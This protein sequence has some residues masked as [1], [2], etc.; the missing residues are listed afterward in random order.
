MRGNRGTSYGLTYAGGSIPAHAGQPHSEHPREAADQVYPRACGATLSP[1]C[2]IVSG[3]GLSPRMR[4]N[5]I[6]VDAH[7][8]LVRSIPAH[9]GQPLFR[10]YRKCVAS[11][12]P[13]A[14]GATAVPILLWEG[15]EGL[16]PRMRGNQ[17]M[18]NA[19]RNIARSIPAHA[20]QPGYDKRRA[21]YREVYPRACGATLT[22]SMICSMRHGLSP[23][24]RGNR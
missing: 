15:G 10:P 17:D 22:P 8:R 24:M 18:T 20:G 9:A 3:C 21:Q 1:P 4:G 19:A 11:V 13:R 5:L 12:Y 2:R 7:G 23:R 14:C 6:R 16:S